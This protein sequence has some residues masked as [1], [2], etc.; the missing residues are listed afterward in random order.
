MPNLSL[1]EISSTK[2]LCSSFDSLSNESEQIE[3]EGDPWRGE[4]LIQLKF[5]EQN[6]SRQ[7]FY[8]IISPTQIIKVYANPTND[9]RSIV[10]KLKLNPTARSQGQFHL[11]R[12]PEET[13]VIKPSTSSIVH[14]GP[15]LSKG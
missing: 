13:A 15:T 10:T 4:I 12:L 6:G 14:Q 1:S 5:Q 2:S 11:G 9:K 7:K 8:L 3:T